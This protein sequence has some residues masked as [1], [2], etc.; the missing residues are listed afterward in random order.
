LIRKQE[1]YANEEKTVN[2]DSPIVF[3]IHLFLQTLQPFT[4]KFSQNSDGSLPEGETGDR[5]ATVLFYVSTAF[6]LLFLGHRSLIKNKT[7]TAAI[8]IANKRTSTNPTS[9]MPDNTH[10]QK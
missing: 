6:K 3:K 8:N 2:K 1:A 4:S 10:P 9:R 5:I 7:Q